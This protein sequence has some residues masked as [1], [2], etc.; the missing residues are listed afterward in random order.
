MAQDALAILDDRTLRS[1]KQRA[2]AR[3]EEFTID[4][5]LPHYLDL[6]HRA[7]DSSVS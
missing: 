4:R 2:K 1:F 6:Y 3:A 7:L 5:I